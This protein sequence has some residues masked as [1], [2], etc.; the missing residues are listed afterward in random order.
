MRKELIALA[1]II[2][3]A[4][5]L[6]APQDTQTLAKPTT[7]SQDSTTALPHAD[8][9]LKDPD[10]TVLRS[11]KESTTSH[12]EDGITSEEANNIVI[13]KYKGTPQEGNIQA[14]SSLYSDGKFY[15]DAYANDTGKKVA[16]YIVYGNGKCTKVEAN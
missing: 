16:S 7:A 9:K 10:S 3:G 15:I 2:V 1:T 5:L 14:G 8:E 11:E 12:S 4:S 13:D 6:D